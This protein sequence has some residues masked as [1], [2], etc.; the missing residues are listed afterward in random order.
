MHCAQRHSVHGPTSNCGNRPSFP[1][2]PRCLESCA[3]LVCTPANHLSFA[4]DSIET[5]ERANLREEERDVH[6]ISA[7]VPPP[8][9]KGI[10]SRKCRCH[11][12]R[13]EANDERRAPLD[14]FWFSCARH[15]WQSRRPCSGERFS[16][17]LFPGISPGKQGGSS[18][19]RACFPSYYAGARWWH[20][21]WQ[22]VVM[23]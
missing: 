12:R 22:A 11:H 21:V 1:Y 18:W 17:L 14:H 20:S 9:E 3:A 19:H 13:H 6:L 10:V 7:A 2:A 4:E 23:G 8:R 15:K 16:R 5:R